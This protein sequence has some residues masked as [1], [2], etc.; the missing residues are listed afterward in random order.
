MGCITI[1]NQLVNSI[2]K[3]P[4]IAIELQTDVNHIGSPT[5][6]FLRCLQP[7][8]YWLYPTCSIYSPA[9][10]PLISW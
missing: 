4:K 1:E 10:N 3:S 6:L 9:L 5:P 7:D 2:M 8:K